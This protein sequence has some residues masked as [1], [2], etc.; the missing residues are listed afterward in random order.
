[1]KKIT[2][3]ILTAVLLIANFILCIGMS[4]TDN[5]TPAVSD[6]QPDADDVIVSD[7]DTAVSDSIV[8]TPDSAVPSE[9]DVSAPP[10]G[11]DAPEAAPNEQETEP[12]TPPAQVDIPPEAYEGLTTGDNGY[13]VSKLQN[14]LS[15]LGY[16]T[17]TLDGDFGKNTENAIKTFQRDAGLHITGVANQQTIDLLFSDNAPPAPESSDHEDVRSPSYSRDYYIII[18][19][20]NGSAIV[21]GKDDY[22]HYN[23]LVKSILCSPGLPGHE[24]P[25]K[26]YKIGE[27]YDWRQ[28]VTGTYAQYAIRLEG[29]IM[30]HSVP[31]SSK[32]PE[33]LLMEEYEKLGQPGSLGCIR[34]C[35]SDIKWIYDNA[36]A[37]T[38]V[39]V[40]TG[41]NGP[42]PP[43]AAELNHNEPY[44]GWDPTDPNPESPYNKQ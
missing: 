6:S 23:K 17:G 16:L 35:V 37:G 9:T 28:M 12:V 22:G 40:I 11:S 8:Q 44:N 20:D 38:Q 7:A 24:T 43:A 18:Y 33:K 39:L 25:A 31:Y 30:L 21:L 5:D 27:K 26:L 19:R 42:E 36:P 2:L 10:S 14:R 1:M 13:E 15:K 4:A 3:I 29:P 41:K 34:M 32:S